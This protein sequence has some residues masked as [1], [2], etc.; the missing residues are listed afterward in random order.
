M[1]FC[2]QD[3]FV[4]FNRKRDNFAIATGAIPMPVDD[5]DFFNFFK[6]YDLQ[7]QRTYI[8]ENRSLLKNI[9]VNFSVYKND[10]P[11]KSTFIKIFNLILSKLKYKDKRGYYNVDIVDLYNSYNI[12]VCPNEIIGVVGIGLIEGIACG[13]CPIVENDLLLEQYG[14][15]D[16]INYIS[17][18]GSI[19]DLNDKLDFIKNNVELRNDIIKN[20]AKQIYRF[21]SKN[22]LND[23]IGI[24]ND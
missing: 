16:G 11:K 24:L 6:S 21:Y 2:I 14:F 15:K 10:P 1:P 17:Y 18:N 4:N 22:I 12:I 8:Y 20:N 7:K 13:M 23:F 5:E 3:R 19:S 9:F